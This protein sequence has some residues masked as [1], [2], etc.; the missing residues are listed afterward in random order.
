MNRNTK[1]IAVNDNQR[2]YDYPDEVNYALRQNYQR[3][4][5][6][7]PKFKNSSQK[8]IYSNANYKFLD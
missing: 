8:S 3:G 4:Y 7:E 6:N 2:E 1:V 5:I